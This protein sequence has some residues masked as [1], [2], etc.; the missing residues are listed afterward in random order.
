[1]TEAVQSQPKQSHSW[2]NLTV[3]FGCM[4]WYIAGQPGSQ[5]G[6]TVLR[7]RFQ[8]NLSIAD[9]L[10]VGP[11]LAQEDAVDFPDGAPWICITF[12][13]ME[14]I[15]ASEWTSGEIPGSFAI[16]IIARCERKLL[17]LQ[18]LRTASRYLIDFGRRFSPTRKTS[19][20]NT[21]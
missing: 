20:T 5:A 13:L 12:K 2:C 3:L 18:T 1:V 8:C 16:E 9:H 11:S 6:R 17:S 21:L 4:N 19:R 7:P 15:S 14:D 10:H